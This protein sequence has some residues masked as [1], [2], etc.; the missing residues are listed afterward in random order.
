MCRNNTNPKVKT[1]STLS[2]GW[3]GGGLHLHQKPSDAN[4]QLV[5]FAPASRCQL[6]AQP[7]LILVQVSVNGLA[8]AFHTELTRAHL[9]QTPRNSRVCCKSK[10]R[11]GIRKGVSSTLLDCEVEQRRTAE[12]MVVQQHCKHHMQVSHR[13]VDTAFPLFAPPWTGI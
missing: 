1:H 4:L 6:L 8:L 3:G 5:V 11:S 13:T 7:R 10:S 12:Q 9:C 2:F